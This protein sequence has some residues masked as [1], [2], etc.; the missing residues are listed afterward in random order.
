LPVRLYQQ[1]SGGKK[2]GEREEVGREGVFED[3][4]A[5]GLASR[6]VELVSGVVLSWVVDESSGP[7]TTDL[8]GV[9]SWNK[10]KLQQSDIR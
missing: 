5:D 9:M 3:R 4:R 7:A 1:L 10:F 6:W 8:D 2:P